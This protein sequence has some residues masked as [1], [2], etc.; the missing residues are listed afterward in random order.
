V[1]L[2]DPHIGWFPNGTDSLFGPNPA[3]RV[4]PYAT[5]ILGIPPTWVKPCDEVLPTFGG[6]PLCDDLAGIAAFPFLSPQTS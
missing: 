1:P 3:K 2:D 6:T 4:V 5:A